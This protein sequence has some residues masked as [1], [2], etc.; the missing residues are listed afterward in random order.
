M[1]KVVNVLMKIGALSVG[2]QMMKMGTADM[3]LSVL[4]IAGLLLWFS[5][6]KGVKK[7]YICW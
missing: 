3:S 4:I 2:L 1:K 5:T 7:S 6:R